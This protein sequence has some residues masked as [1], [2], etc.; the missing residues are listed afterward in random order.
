MQSLRQYRQSLDGTE[1]SFDFSLGKTLP[2]WLGTDGNIVPLDKCTECKQTVKFRL[3]MY[4]VGS[5]LKSE[6]QL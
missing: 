1:V 2:N 6:I 4:Y 5:I 3:I